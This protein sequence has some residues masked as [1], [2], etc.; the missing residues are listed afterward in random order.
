MAR[1]G[2]ISADASDEQMIYKARAISPDFPGLLDFP[3]VEHWPQ[4]LPPGCPALR[5]LPMRETCPTSLNLQSQQFQ[6]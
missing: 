5:G 6:I 1:L 2:L 4:H 3:L